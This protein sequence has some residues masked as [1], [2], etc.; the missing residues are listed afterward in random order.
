MTKRTVIGEGSYG[1][2]V[3]PSVECDDNYSVQGK[4]SKIMKN[5]H[6]KEELKEFERVS[7]I[8]GIYRFIIEKP[9]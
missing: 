6:A 7:K 3:K 9:H 4:I 8:S 5:K 1:C 2:V